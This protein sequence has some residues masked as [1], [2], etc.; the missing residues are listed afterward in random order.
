MTGV[1]TCALPISVALYP[2]ERSIAGNLPKATVAGRGGGGKRAFLMFPATPRKIIKKTRA[3]IPIT[4]QIEAFLEKLA[5]SVKV[6]ILQFD[7][8]IKMHKFFC[9]PALVE[10]SHVTI[11]P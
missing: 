4:T 9:H 8:K 3:T 7:K 5:V 6:D 1:Q 2:S 11:L 10:G